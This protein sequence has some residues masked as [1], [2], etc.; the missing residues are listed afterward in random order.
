MNA[1]NLAGRRGVGDKTRSEGVELDFT[2]NPLPGLSFLGSYNFT[3][4]NE[5]LD[6]HPL[7]S[8]PENFELFGRPDH[9][10]TFTGRYKFRDGSLKGLTIG[11]SQ[12]YRS[13][14]NQTRFDL[15]YDGAGNPVGES[16]AGGRTDRVYLN[17]GDEHTTLS[18][19]HI[20]EPTR[21]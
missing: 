5:I 17:F 3:V 19:I 6:L 8:N 14:S 1:A 16:V 10:V 21:R 20:S 12:R 18:L 9:R 13:A 11:A 7:V 4:A 15:H 2:Y